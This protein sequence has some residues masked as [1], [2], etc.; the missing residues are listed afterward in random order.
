MQYPYTHT[1]LTLG[2]WEIFKSFFKSDMNRRFRLNW[3]VSTPP[4]P[5]PS[6]CYD[7]VC[8]RK[9]TGKG[10]QNIFN[11]SVR[12]TVKSIR[13]GW[14]HISALHILKHMINYNWN[15]VNWQ[16]YQFILLQLSYL[17]R[18]ACPPLHRQSQKWQ[19]LWGGGHL[20]QF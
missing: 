14:K 5:P 17:R 3:G 18:K 7:S 12:K 4:P 11:L 13:C 6:V 19:R 16:N 2:K 9:L 1:K 20:D 10:L 15:N 8:R